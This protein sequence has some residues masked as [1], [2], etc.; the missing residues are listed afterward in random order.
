MGS[1]FEIKNAYL[2]TYPVLR[3]HQKVGTQYLEIPV[4][5]YK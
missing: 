1:I 5:L 2:L 3:V 4:I